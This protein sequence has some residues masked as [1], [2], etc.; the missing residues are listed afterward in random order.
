[1]HPHMYVYKYCELQ[2]QVGHLHSK[3][4]KRIYLL[5]V[6]SNF[7]SYKYSMFVILVDLLDDIGHIRTTYQDIKILYLDMI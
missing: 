7:H 3:A 2:N 5:I 1:M 4:F 6:L